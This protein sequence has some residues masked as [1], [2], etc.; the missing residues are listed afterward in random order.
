MSVKQECD[1]G[2][3]VY[4][5]SGALA[6]VAFSAIGGIKLMQT[7]IA[8]DIKSPKSFKDACVAIE[9]V[10]PQ[11]AD[12]GWGFP[13]EKWDFYGVFKNRDLVPEGIKN[14]VVYF[15]CNARLANK[16]INANNAM[17]GIMPCSCAVYE[18]DK[19]EVY[20][21]KMNI[22][23]MSKMFSGDIK[24]MMLEVEETEKR[25]FDKIFSY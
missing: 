14:I 25:M 23:L 13:F 6:G 2:K 20:I 16:V 15:I 1:V 21:A 5:L 8:I 19:G 12:E 7:K 4:A 10:I 3:T 22:G 9:N 17:M 11:F 18:N 24:E